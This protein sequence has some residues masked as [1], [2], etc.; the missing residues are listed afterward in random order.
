MRKLSQLYRVLLERMKDRK[1]VIG[2]EVLDHVVAMCT[3]RTI[4]TDEH[5]RLI[6]HLRINK[7][8]AKLHKEFYNHYLFDKRP[9]VHRWWK[10]GTLRDAKV[11]KA[12]QRAF[13]RRMITETRH[14][15]PKQ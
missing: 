7:P 13:V 3:D 5:Y 10:P 9:K 4:T 8:T 12:Q 14:G 11:S 6:T 2:A 1:D 15:Q